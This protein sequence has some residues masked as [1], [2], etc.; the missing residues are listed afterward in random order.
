MSH[1]CLKL[2]NGCHIIL[3]KHQ[4]P[5]AAYKPLQ[6]CLR[7]LWHQLCLAYSAVAH[8]LPHHA[9]HVPASI[10]VLAVCS[11]LN[12]HM[13]APPLLIRSVLSP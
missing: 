10:F 12:M 9:N 5:C 11:F 4:T 13:A 2:Y 8:V 1:L 3:S 6:I 7:L